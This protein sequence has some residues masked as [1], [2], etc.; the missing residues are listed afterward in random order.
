MMKIKKPL[1]WLTV[2]TLTTGS[3]FAQE[4]PSPA[5]SAPPPPHLGPIADHRPPPPPDGAQPGGDE[6]EHGHHP[7][8]MRREGRHHEAGTFLGVGVEE[9]PHALADQLSLPDGFGVLVNFVVPGSAAQAAGVQRDDVLKMLNDQILV[10]PEQLST[11]VRSYPDGQDVTLTVIRKG[12]ETKLTAKLKRETFPEGHERLEGPGR[13][14]DDHGFM[15]PGMDRP[16]HMMFDGREGREEGREDGDRSGP[17]GPP[18]PPVRDIM[19]ELRPELRDLARQK[20]DMAEQKADEQLQHEIMILRERNG[21]S[22]STRLDLQDARIVIRDDKGELE[23]KSNA[24]QRF[25]TAKD[26][27]GKVVFN[28]PVNTPAERKAVPGDVLPR[29]E[30]L[31]KEEMPAFP[32]APAP[33][34]APQGATTSQNTS[35]APAAVG[36]AVQSSTSF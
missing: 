2:A 15:H 1:A 18:A 21:A 7:G 33:A 8:E 25:L 12:K 34:P 13:E 16:D 17:P 31:E 11:L 4:S 30:K 26:A 24:G 36:G 23:L 32:E 29:L 3:V 35:P 28:G 9:V 22:R 19:R 5:P 10:N 27:Q 14:G 6:P 20:A